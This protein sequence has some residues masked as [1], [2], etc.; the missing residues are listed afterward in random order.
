MPD[1]L[2]ENRLRG[3]RVWSIGY[4][5]FVSS[6]KIDLEEHASA[7]L[8]INGACANTC[9]FLELWQTPRVQLL[10]W[11]ASMV[12]SIKIMYRVS[13]NVIHHERK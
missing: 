8:L 10:Q 7:V 4:S 1:S 9:G 12:S 13:D 2:P 5:D 3:K 11:K 6:S